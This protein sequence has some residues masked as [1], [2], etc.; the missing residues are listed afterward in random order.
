M[1][2]HLVFPN[3]PP[4]GATG[5]KLPLLKNPMV[6]IPMFNGTGDVLNWLYQMELVF[7]IHDTPMKERVEFCVFYPRQDAL[8]WWRWFQKQKGSVSWH[9]F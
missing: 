6:D 1:R 9:E 3:P 7:T 4:S 2:G 8:V 5:V